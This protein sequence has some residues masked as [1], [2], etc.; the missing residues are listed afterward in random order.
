LRGAG[1]AGRRRAPQEEEYG[2]GEEG[3]DSRA[4]LARSV[5]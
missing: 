3:L 2:E 4:T 1:R 5:N